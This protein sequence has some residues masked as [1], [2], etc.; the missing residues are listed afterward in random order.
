MEISPYNS[1]QRCL[2]ESQIAQNYLK[3][4][5]RFVTSSDYANYEA[6]EK[7]CGNW[8]FAKVSNGNHR[9]LKTISNKWRDLLLAQTMPTMKL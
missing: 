3:E 6:I 8:L 9:L 2:W 5:E 4:V 7:W 1:R